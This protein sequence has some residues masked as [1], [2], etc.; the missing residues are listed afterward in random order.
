ML[1]LILISMLNRH[2]CSVEAYLIRGDSEAIT[3]CMFKHV[4][5]Q[6]YT[7]YGGIINHVLTAHG[8]RAEG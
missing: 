6:I 1:V 2:Q 4:T 8:I 3:S 7:K 5:E